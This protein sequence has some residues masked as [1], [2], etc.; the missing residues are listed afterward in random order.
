MNAFLSRFFWREK[1]SSCKPG[2]FHSVFILP[3]NP[4]KNLL[5]SIS[6]HTVVEGKCWKAVSQPPTKNSEGFWLFISANPVNKILN[7]VTK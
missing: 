2:G 7:T 4:S 6:F 5:C 3:M 1:K